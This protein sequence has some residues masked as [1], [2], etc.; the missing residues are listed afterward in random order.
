[1]RP[2]TSAVRQAK[3]LGEPQVCGIPVMPG[4]GLRERELEY[5]PYL[6]SPRHDRYEVVDFPRPKY[7]TYSSEGP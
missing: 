2:L 1:M 5:I 4:T 3:Y 7:T 6:R